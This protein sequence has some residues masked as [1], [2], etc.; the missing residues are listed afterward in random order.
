MQQHRTEASSDYNDD[1]FAWTQH[2]AK[3]LRI[4]DRLGSELPTGLDITKIAEEI[5]GLGG[6]DLSAVKSWIRQIFVHLIKVASDPNAKAT[7]HWQ[8]EAASF[9]ADMLDRYTA[10]MRQLI[11]MQPLWNSALKIAQLRLRE[12]DVPLARSI[13]VECPY[14]VQDIVSNEFE[15]DEALKRLRT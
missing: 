15:F 2:Q 7:M 14:S 9:H 13:P 4:L 12:H 3:L 5:E 1:F 8:A 11:D 6:S 10:S